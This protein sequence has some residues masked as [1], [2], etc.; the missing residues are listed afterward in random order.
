MRSCDSLLP[1]LVITS[2]INVVEY[3]WAIQRPDP[4]AG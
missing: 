2:M 1:P 4:A 3:K